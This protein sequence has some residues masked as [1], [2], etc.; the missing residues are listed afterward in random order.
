M[1]WIKQ[2]AEEKHATPAQL[3]L[4]WMI[5]K[6]PYVVPIP[7]TRK[8]NRLGERVGDAFKDGAQLK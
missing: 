7:G 5:A 8:V 2:L 4:A 1:R 3:S 6:K